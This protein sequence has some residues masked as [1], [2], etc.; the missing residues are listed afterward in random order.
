[1]GAAHPLG[2]TT[3]A[4]SIVP[5]GIKYKHE[6]FQK[7]SFENSNSKFVTTALAEQ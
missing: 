4:M 5:E 3:I 1:V 6:I 2:S 7:I